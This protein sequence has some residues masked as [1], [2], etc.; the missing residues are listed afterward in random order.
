MKNT[1]TN[2]QLLNRLQELCEG[3]P[4]EMRIRERENYIAP[5]LYT[6]RDAPEYTPSFYLDED[7][8]LTG[9]FRIG[10]QT[11]SYGA[12]APESI[13]EVA[14]GLMAAAELAKAMSVQIQLAGFRVIAG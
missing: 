9:S 3:T 13:M 4:Y 11:T 12:L 6:R 1:P 8:D 5:Y 7:W 10:V 14:Q 2:R